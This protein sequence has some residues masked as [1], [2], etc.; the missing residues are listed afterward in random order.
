MARQPFVHICYLLQVL[1]PWELGGHP[2][3][4]SLKVNAVLNIYT[5]SSFQ[6]STC[7]L[8]GI[9]QA[10]TRK[11]MQEVTD[12]ISAKVHNFVHFDQDQA[13]QHAKAVG[14]PQISGFPWVQG[15]INCTHRYSDLWDIKL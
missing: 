1:V 8:C 10:S 6:G 2:L 7:D 5:S 13:S 4:V 12:A 3:P 15:T 9:L 11:C 14:F